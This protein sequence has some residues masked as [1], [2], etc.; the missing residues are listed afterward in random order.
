M[1]SPD[2]DENLPESEE[3]K[4]WHT[5]TLEAKPFAFGGYADVYRGSWLPSGRTER[6]N[7]SRFIAFSGRKLMQIAQVAAKVL[8]FTG[9]SRDMVQEYQQQLARVDKVRLRRVGWIA[10]F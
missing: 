10:V 8:R 7:V 9:M 3:I 4:D 1:P 5:I 6:L 2:S